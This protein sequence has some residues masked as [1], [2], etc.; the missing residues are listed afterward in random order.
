MTPDRAQAGDPSPAL[1]T[2]RVPQL[3]GLRGV[4]IALVMMHHF[5]LLSGHGWLEL[6]LRRAGKLGWT[7]VDL[8]FVLSG[9]LI[10]G[11]L[12]RHRAAPGYYRS[13]YVRR[14]LR[15]VP[16]YYAYLAFAFFVMPALVHYDLHIHPLWF[17]L[18]A[19]NLPIAIQGFPNP[20][21]D[22][23]WSLAV[24]EQFYLLW[25]LLVSLTPP[26]RLAR[27]CLLLVCLAPLT[28]LGL[29]LGGE[30]WPATY[31]L[32]P[33]RL[34]GLALGSLAACLSAHQQA[35]AGR[36]APVTA[37]L[38]ALGVGGLAAYTRSAHLYGSVGQVLGY[39]LTSG[40]A[41]SLLLM[42]LE[43]R[44]ASRLLRAPG[45]QSL[46]TYSYAL[47]LIHVPVGVV[48]RRR[49][50][51]ADDWP[52]LVG[53]PLL[54]QALYYLL[55]GSLSFG[56]AWLSWR[57]LEAPILRLKRHFPYG[58]PRPALPPSVRLSVP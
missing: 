42:A 15:I 14:A 21:L 55:A 5:T 11:I 41:F 35:Q 27:V 1:P 7:G 46:G 17:W 44:V 9:Y 57:F 48:L 30:G 13:F 38:C 6:G 56:L 53:S 49:G 39:T 32:M 2:S 34:D 24:E 25:P 50:F 4:A 10:T 52:A 22:I 28:R 3:D 31:V 40:V 12:R 16:L 8:F 19:S 43:G 26:R 51:G 54:G 36:W 29:S 33:C 18:H 47:Y 23:V 37:V 45:L 20:I 58:R